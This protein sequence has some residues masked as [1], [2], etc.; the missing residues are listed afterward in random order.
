MARSL[1]PENFGVYSFFVS[2]LALGVGVSKGGLDPIILRN[3]I[4]KISIADFYVKSASI[5]RG[6]IVLLGASF[7]ICC[8]YNLYDYGRLNLFFP[9]IWIMLALKSLDSVELWFHARTRIGEVLKPKYFIFIASVF[10]KIAAL[11]FIPSVSILLT[12]TLIETGIASVAGWII[13][14]K[15]NPNNIRKSSYTVVYLKN[16]LKTAWPIAFSS[17]IIISYQKLQSVILPFW[18][19]KKEYGEYMAA[20]RITEMLYFIPIAISTSLLPRF[21]SARKKTFYTEY[22]VNSAFMNLFSIMGLALGLILSFIG[23]FLIDI[24]YGDMY[25]ESSGIF[26]IHIWS[27]VFV[28]LGV[29]RSQVMMNQGLNKYLLRFTCIG[30][31]FNIILTYYLAINFSTIG[32]AFAI[33]I[34]TFVS[35]FLVTPLFKETRTIFRSQLS[36]LFG[37]KSYRLV[38]EILTRKRT[39]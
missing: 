12:I 16:L 19:T 18:I 10:A 33:V 34:S 32:V 17:F 15:K 26:S 3:I 27:I 9:V 5:Y 38:F 24:L 29:S 22:E 6:L 7:M 1:G 11:L 28:F 21:L 2:V 8:F 4:N 25:S 30:L 36:G 13:Y 31:V 37:L 23:P 39:I 35:N 20:S 14:K